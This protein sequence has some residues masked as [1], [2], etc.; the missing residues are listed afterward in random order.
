MC[1][2]SGILGIIPRGLDWY[3]RNTEMAANPTGAFM[4][5]LLCA[6]HVAKYFTNVVYV[7]SPCWVSMIVLMMIS[8]AEKGSGISLRHQARQLRGSLWSPGLSYS[9]MCILP[10]LRGCPTFLFKEIIL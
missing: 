9:K 6:R 7:K 4:K 10:T 1:V 8:K 3:G 2:A 5:Q